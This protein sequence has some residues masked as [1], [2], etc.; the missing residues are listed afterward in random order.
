MRGLKVA[1]FERGDFAVGTSSRSSKLVHGGLRYLEQRA[2]GLV[3]EACAE[4]RALQRIA[5]HLVRPRSFVIPAYRGQKPGRWQVEAG[6][7]IYDAVALFRNTRFHRPLGRRSIEA[8]EPGLRSEGLAGGGLFFDCV[9]DD[10]RLT[11]ANVLD[12]Q[13]LGAVCMNYAPVV[14]VSVEGA[15][16]KGVT[17]ARSEERR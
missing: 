6:M 4:R 1:L 5:P 8:M 15:R 12:A 9:T 17:V 11:L 14:A 3:S 2:F 10:A 16:V 7:W 13:S